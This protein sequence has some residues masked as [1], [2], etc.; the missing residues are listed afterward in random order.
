MDDWPEPGTLSLQDERS[1]GAAPVIRGRDRE[2]R[3]LAD[4]VRRPAKRQNALLVVGERGSGKS[5]LLDL[6]SRLADGDAVVVRAKGRGSLANGGRP[7]LDQ[8][9]QGVADQGLDSATRPSDADRLLLATSIFQ[10]LVRASASRP[11]LLVVD[12]LHLADPLSTFVCAFV[13][14]RLRATRVGF[15]GACSPVTE[16]ATPWDWAEAHRLAPLPAAACVELLDHEFPGM[17]D[18]VRHRVMTEGHGNPARL[19]AIAASLSEEQLRGLQRVADVS[20]LPSPS[21]SEEDSHAVVASLPAPTVELLLLAALE[22]KGDMRAVRAAAGQEGLGL[23][24]LAAAEKARL[25]TLD[26]RGQTIVFKDPWVRAAVVAR[27]TA[28]ERRAAHRRL[29]GAAAGHDPEAE[30]WHRAEALE[31]QDGAVALELDRLARRALAIGDRH[32]AVDMLLKASEVA[33]SDSHRSDLLALAAHVR[34]GSP[35][36]RAEAPQLTAVPSDRTPPERPQSTAT[37]AYVSLTEGLDPEEVFQFVMSSI[38]DSDPISPDDPEL[39]ELCYILLSCGL[40][41]ANPSLWETYRGVLQRMGPSVPETLRIL[42]RIAPDVARIDPGHLQELDYALDRVSAEEDPYA[43]LRLGIAAFPVDRLGQCREPLWHLARGSVTGGPAL[44]ASVEAKLR[45]CLD[46][47]TTGQWDEALELA[48]EGI[49]LCDQNGLDIQGHTF[50]LCQAVIAACR[51][52]I[53]TAAALAAKLSAWALPRGVDLVEFQSGYVR[54]LAALGSGDFPSAYQQASSISSAGTL[55]PFNGQAVWVCLD[56]V[57]SAVHTE[58]FAE[59]LAHTEAIMGSSIPHLSPRL[60][61][62]AATAQALTSTSDDEAAGHFHRAL[63]VPGADRWVFDTARTQLLYGERLRRTSDAALAR[64]QLSASLVRFRALGADPWTAR[65]AAGLR[66]AGVP[67]LPEP[68]DPGAVLT[69]RE[70]KI[71]SLAASGLTNREI[72]AQ[73]FLS[74]RTVASL[75]YKLFPKLGV[76]SRAALRDALA[77]A[78]VSLGDR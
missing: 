62:R 72:G 41:A 25:V 26:V 66:A 14:R 17:A 5:A 38:A 44:A 53:E 50:R 15:L 27:A 59:A 24:A 43:V 54:T 52:D 4:F 58:R 46:D 22:V 3:L 64:T 57:E 7:V 10:S 51:G 63:T 9:L 71:A 61:Q 11:L 60:A 12:D 33:E 68:S 34:S 31:G 28:A 55:A 32:A 49:T 1:G 47:S 36:D 39:I 40:L 75:L 74:H 70:L 2:I 30:A 6:A 42:S 65:A 76:T 16:G 78:A 13:G 77:T 67:R 37:A 56:L 45:L 35:Q 8:L 69:A 18:S 20:G 19:R 48:H 23:N 73:L 29:A 21:V